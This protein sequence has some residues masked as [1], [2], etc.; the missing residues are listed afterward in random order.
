MKRFLQILGGFL[1]LAGAIPF[2]TYFL[3]Y[4]RMTEFAQGYVVGKGL[5]ILIGL[6][7]LFFSR[8]IK[9]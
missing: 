4:N 5:L 1:V 7:L 3:D 6:S 9:S 2:F 8:K